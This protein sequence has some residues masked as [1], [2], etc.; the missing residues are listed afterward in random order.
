[1]VLVSYN[2]MK[3]IILTSFLKVIYPLKRVPKIMKIIVSGLY[4]QVIQCYGYIL[5]MK[6][7]KLD[8][9]SETNLDSHTLL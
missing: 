1:M 2:V 6:M 8:R 3:K 7:T 9:W 4:L 5:I